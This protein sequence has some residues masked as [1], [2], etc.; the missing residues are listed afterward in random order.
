MNQLHLL[1]LFYQIFTF[2]FASSLE[3]VQF[4]LYTNEDSTGFDITEKNHDSFN[5]YIY[6]F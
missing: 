1:I 6:D 3:G 5:R 2:S 4:M